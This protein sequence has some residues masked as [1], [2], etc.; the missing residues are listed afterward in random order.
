VL[1]NSDSLLLSPDQVTT[2]RANETRYRSTVDSLWTALSMYL[3]AL[4]DE[5]D[6]KAAYAHADSVVDDAWEIT[7]LDVPPHMPKILTPVQRPLLG[8]YSGRLLN[9]PARLHVRIF[10][11]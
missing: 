7:R 6:M 3:A 10:V 1:Q 11:P 8:G 4:P 9:A 2:I 5:Y